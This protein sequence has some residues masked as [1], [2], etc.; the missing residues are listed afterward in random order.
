M[1]EKTLEI[2]VF[3]DDAKQISDGQHFIATISSVE[4]HT[5]ATLT[6]AAGAAN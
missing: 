4:G 6:R 3:G 1:S 5:I 2:K